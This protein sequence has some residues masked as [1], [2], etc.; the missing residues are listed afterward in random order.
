VTSGTAAPYLTNNTN[1]MT[2]Q[3]TVGITG[4][5]FTATVPARSMVT[6]RI[7]GGTGAI[8]PAP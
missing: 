4:G 3:S 5:T 2:A 1:S 8:M 6:Y 7:T